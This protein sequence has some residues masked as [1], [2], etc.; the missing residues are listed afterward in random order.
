MGSRKEAQLVQGAAQGSLPI[1]AVHV[2]LLFIPAWLV[3]V[4]VRFV[5][6]ARDHVIDLNPST[7]R[8]AQVKLDL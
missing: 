4:C 3:C 7:Y 5:S 6:K 8:G 2:A 1:H